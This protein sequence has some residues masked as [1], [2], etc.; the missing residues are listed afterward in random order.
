M[1]GR[2]ATRTDGTA[3]VSGQRAGLTPQSAAPADDWRNANG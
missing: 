1:V 3:A 2:T